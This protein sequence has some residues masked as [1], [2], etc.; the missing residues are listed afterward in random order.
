MSSLHSVDASLSTH[1]VTQE[2]VRILWVVLVALI[3]GGFWML[4]E[5][6]V[7]SFLEQQKTSSSVQTQTLQQVSEI[8][9][10]MD[11]ADFNTMRSHINQL[12]FD[13]D[14]IRKD[15]ESYKADT[16]EDIEHILT[17]ITK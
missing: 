4:A 11:I 9:M 14:Q 10:Q 7:D 13:R 16:K 6:A 8:R 2:K 1:A 12:Q 17:K 5:R 15:F 3:A